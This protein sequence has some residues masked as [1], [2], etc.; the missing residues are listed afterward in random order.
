MKRKHQSHRGNEHRSNLG[1]KGGRQAGG[2]RGHPS[3]HVLWEMNKT[4]ICPSA[5]GHRP[6][7]GCTAGREHCTLASS[8]MS[9]P[10][11]CSN[12]S[13]TARPYLSFIY[14]VRLRMIARLSA[15][16]CVCARTCYS[17]DWSVGA[18][19]FSKLVT[20]FKASNWH[21]STPT[22]LRVTRGSVK[23]CIWKRRKMPS[24]SRQKVQGWGLVGAL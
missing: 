11:K 16:L 18:L 24:R 3:C 12:R 15:C 4:N 13:L 7:N 5:V 22:A 21:D 9:H 1:L 6:L 2:G 23:A 10:A 19:L 8:A 14:P 17:A 20:Y